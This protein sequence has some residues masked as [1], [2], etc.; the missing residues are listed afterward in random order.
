MDMIKSLFLRSDFKEAYFKYNATKHTCATGIY[1][2]FCCGAR[3]AECEI[4]SDPNTIQIQLGVDD[5]DVAAPLKSKTTKHKMNAVYFQIRNMPPEFN[6]KLDSIYLVS[7]CNA[8]HFGGEESTDDI[9][10]LFLAD[11]R[12]LETTGVQID[13]DHN[14]KG[15]LINTSFDNLGGNS[16][17]GF[18]ESFS[19]TYYCR[20]C[21]LD[22]VECKTQFTEVEQKMRNNRNYMRAIDIIKKSDQRDLKATKGISRYCPFN[23]LKFYNIFQN[24]SVD[25]M[26]D[27]NEG[28]IPVLIHAFIDYAAEKKIV[29]YSET[30]RKVRDYNYGFLSKRN[31]PSQINKD[32]PNLNQN[33]SQQYCLMRHL[34]FIF[35][36]Y[37]EKLGVP[38]KIMTDL[39]RIMEIL[40]SEIITEND[41]CRLEVLIEQYLYELVNS[42][43]VSLYPK[44]HFLTHYPN[45]IRRMGPVIHSWM[46]RYESK[47]KTF[48]DVGKDTHNFI[49]LASTLAKEHQMQLCNK[50]KLIRDNISA[51]KRCKL[52]A[53]CYELHKYTRILEASVPNVDLD[54]LRVLDFV[55]WNSFQYRKG[56]LI[57]NTNKL[58]EIIFIVSMNNDFQLFCRPYELVKFDEKFNSIEIAAKEHSEN[59]CILLRIDEMENKKSF[60]KVVCNKRM[61]IMSTSLDVRNLI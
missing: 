46:M 47:H 37:E 26:H 55:N 52:F 39:L 51:S 28:V 61:Y 20:L 40:Y 3:Y 27:M 6:S 50:K 29:T 17:F 4:F 10:K 11:V 58:F 1:R 7:L 25:L 8:K 32:K 45:V 35:S 33:A 60:D 53:V 56:L 18:T 36:E 2:D 21:E 23:D 13:A 42:L 44:H 12:V 49:N 57:I 16:L 31:K 24:P 54:D 30:Q 59:E 34:P 38:W 9:V 5:F 15:A 22:K 43:N 19:A 14:L 48:T 41:I